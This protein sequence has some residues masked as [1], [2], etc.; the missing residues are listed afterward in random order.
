MNR[1]KCKKTTQYCKKS[2]VKKRHS[3]ELQ[4]VHHKVESREEI[5]IDRS[6]GNNNGLLEQ[7][8]LSTEKLHPYQD[9]VQGPG[10]CLDQFDLL[11]EHR[12]T[13]KFFGGLVYT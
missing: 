13:V 7:E 12:D 4:A 1:L 10:Q 6:E 2:G 8:L 3:H 11:G 5:R 9:S